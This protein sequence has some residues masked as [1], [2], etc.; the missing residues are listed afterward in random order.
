M[1]FD[2]HS[3]ISDRRF[4]ACRDALYQEIRKSE[5]RFVMDVGSDLET[6]LGAV[7]AAE[8]ND[9]CYAVVGCHPHEAKSFDDEQLL[10]IKGLAKKP[11]VKAIGEIGL[12]YH[13]DLSQRDVQRYWFARQVEMANELKMPIVIHDREANEDVLRILKE[14]GAFSF[15]RKSFFPRR[16]DGSADARVLLHCYSGSAELAMQ[17]V[18]LGATI[19]IAGPVTFKNARRAIEVVERVDLSHLLVETDSPYLAPEPYRGK[20]NKPTY[21]EH[22]ARKIA[23]IKKVD[24]ETA[25]RQ[26]F[27]NACR[28][29]DIEI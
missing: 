13:Y 19:S 12:D 21:V 25:S 24:Y 15:E 4:D 26:T 8:A 7:K 16:P 11:K 1:L 3:H 22:V 17:Y 20:T 28:F 2:S 6:S 27:E 14:N 29:F 9:F 5:L 10:L 18:K 23:E